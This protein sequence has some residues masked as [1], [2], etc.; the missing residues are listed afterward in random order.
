MSHQSHQVDEET[1]LLLPEEQHKT[2]T[3]LPWRQLSIILFLQLTE[4]VTAQAISP[5]A[6]QVNS[7]TVF[8]EFLTSLLFSADQRCWHNTWWWI[9]S[10]ILRWYHGE[11]PVLALNSCF[12]IYLQVFRILHSSSPYNPS[13]EPP[14]W[15]C[16]PKASHFDWSLWYIGFDVPIWTFKNLWGVDIEVRSS[17]SYWKYDGFNNSFFFS[18]VLCGALNGNSGVIKSM[19]ID[20]TDSTNMAQAF[21]FLP[22][23]WMTGNTLG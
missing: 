5:F 9:K 6:P 15:S 17:Y 19:M 3:P 11:R 23:P 10:G 4:P 7:K 16:W 22:L 12:L 8:Y 2:K 13:M 14:I 21:G 1:P 18:R 20:I